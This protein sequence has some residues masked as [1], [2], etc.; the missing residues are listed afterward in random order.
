MAFLHIS[1]KLAL[2]QS[3]GGNEKEPVTVRLQPTAIVSG[4]LLDADGHPVAGAE[5]WT[6]YAGPVG[7]QL[8]RSLSQRI[9]QPQ[10]DE[11]GR[12]RLEGIVP[13]L[14]WRFA[15][16][17]GREPLEAATNLDIKPLESG[18]SLD[19]GNIR[20]KPRKK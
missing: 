11:E 20:V 12:F 15:F 5:V 4:R 7:E 6:L 9:I 8:W 19:L 2:L 13:G 10:T 3:V 16:L 1:R 17:K 14:T 18:Q